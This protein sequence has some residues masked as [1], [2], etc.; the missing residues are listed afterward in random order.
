MKRA[1]LRT[2]LIFLLII[3]AGCTSNQEHSDIKNGQ[4]EIM[5]ETAVIETSEGNIEVELDKEKAPITVDNFEK[6]ANSGHYEGTIFHRVIK[7]FMMQ[8]GGFT[9]DGKQKKTRAPIKLESN[10][11]L[12]NTDGTIAMA[13]TSDPNSAT[14]QFFINTAN[15]KFL[16]Y[17]T[18]NDGYA[19]FGRVTKGIEI[20]KKIE[21]AQTTTHGSFEDWPEK[22][23]VIKKI[24]LKS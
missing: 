12:K 8:G 21:S 7:G 9:P 14:S 18:N 4:G 17:T 11:G 19:V 3:F 24:Y 5:K 2:S 1:I 23:I 16:D 22:D 6:Y 15:N 20:V 13:R 10:N